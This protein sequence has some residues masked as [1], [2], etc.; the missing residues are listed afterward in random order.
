MGNDMVVS[1]QAMRVTMFKPGDKVKLKSGGPLMT[2]MGY[3]EDDPLGR[4]IVQ[5][6]WFASLTSSPS[7]HGFY[8][9]ILEKQ[10]AKPT[11][12]VVKK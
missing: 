12:T 5:C 3:K 9:E 11:W 1:N 6:I 7:L 8:E 10:T 2:V 4:D